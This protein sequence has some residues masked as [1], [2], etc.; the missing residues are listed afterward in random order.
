M[1]VVDVYDLNRHPIRYNSPIMNSPIFANF[2][3]NSRENLG[4]ITNK[5]N[6]STWDVSYN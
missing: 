3:F 1:Y 2:Q 5:E 6:I 4:G